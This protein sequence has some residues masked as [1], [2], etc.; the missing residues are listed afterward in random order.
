MFVWKFPPSTKKVVLF[1]G[2]KK[3]HSILQSPVIKSI[4]KPEIFNAIPQEPPCN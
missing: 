1:D 4:I 3:D 2:V